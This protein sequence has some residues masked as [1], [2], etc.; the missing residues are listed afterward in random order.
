MPSINHSKIK[1]ICIIQLQPFGD[2]FLTTSYLGALKE[3][4]PQAEV[5]F[6]TK[7]PYQKVLR[8]HPHIDRL[9]VIPKATGLRYGLERIKSFFKIAFERFDLVIDQQ[10]MLSSQQLALASMARYRIGYRRGR[11]NIPGAYNI[12]I[13]ENN[14]T[15]PLYSASQK[16][17]IVAP[18]GIPSQPYTLHMDITDDEQQKVDDWICETLNNAPFAVISPGSTVE[19]KK[20]SPE[21]FAKVADHLVSKGLIPVI[22]WGPGEEPDVNAVQ[23]R[24]KEKSF[25]ALPTT[26]PEG[27]ALLKRAQIFITNDGGIN[28]LSVPA[29]IPVIAIFGNTHPGNWSPASAF[30]THH[31][32][33]NPDKKSDDPL[34]GINPQAVCDLAGKLLTEK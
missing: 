9:L 30:D 12:I 6:L 29:K 7:A 31:H 1:K 28:H 22:I 15:E 11:R 13:P 21:G 23:S 4:Y 5:V 24:M 32:F 17:E 33:F 26:L 34:W 14:N 19:F 8:N 16:F 2:V 20:W 3:K 10:Y 27:V 18:L 25:K